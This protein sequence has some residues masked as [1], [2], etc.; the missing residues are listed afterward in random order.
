MTDAG[1]SLL[2]V[3]VPGSPDPDPG[4][5][6]I[7]GLSGIADLEVYHGWD[8]L[9]ALDVKRLSATSFVHALSVGSHLHRWL[10]GELRFDGSKASA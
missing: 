6:E 10:L 8:H 1:S 2:R 9:A 3:Q 7:V 5:F 4:S